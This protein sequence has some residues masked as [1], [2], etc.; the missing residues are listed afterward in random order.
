MKIIAAFALAAAST[1]SMAVTLT[2][3]QQSVL[4]QF[5][6]PSEKLAKDALWTSPTMFKV[7]VIDSGTSRDG[8]AQYV[9]GVIGENGLS[10][11]GVMVQIIDIRK[12]VSTDKWVKLGESRCK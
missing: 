3:A 5:K 2:A 12:L 4:S 6:S 11:R 10:G 9:C 8:Y 7:G 1:Y